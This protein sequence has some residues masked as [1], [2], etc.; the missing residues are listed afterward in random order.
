MKKFLSMLTVLVMIT[1]LVIP[2]TA[3]EARGGK[4]VPHVW[5]ERHGD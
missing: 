2:A 1:I 4:C 5:G 3:Q